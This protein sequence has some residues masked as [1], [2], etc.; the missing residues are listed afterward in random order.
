MYF[1]KN[2][3]AYIQNS[4]NKKESKTPQPLGLQ[5]FAF[6]GEGGIWTLARFNTSTPLA[7]EPLRPLGYFSKPVNGSRFKTVSSEFLWRRERDSNPRP[8]RVTGF[9][10]QLHKPLGH[11]S[12]S[13]NALIMPNYPTTRYPVCQRKSEKFPFPHF[14]LFNREK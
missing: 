11:L 13:E 4:A 10:D 14:L 2:R 6:G 8:F 12:I 3:K 5:G 1:L 9:Q 7:G